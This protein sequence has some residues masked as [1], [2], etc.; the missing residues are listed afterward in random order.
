MVKQA[1]EFQAQSEL[2][3]QKAQGS[4][5]MKIAIRKSAPAT[6]GKLEGW[7]GADWATIDHRGTAA[8]FDSNSRPYDVTAAACVAGDRL[9]V[10][11][12]TTEKDLLRNSGEQA[13]APFKTGGC[14]DVMLGVDP[15]AGDGRNDPVPGDMRLLVTRVKDKTVALLYRAKVPGTKEPVPFSSPW[16]TITFDRVT[17]PAGIELASGPISGG[18]FVEAKVPWSI[19]GITPKAG[20]KLRGDF[21]ILSADSG[22]TSCVARQYWNNKA[23]NLVNDVPGE[24]EL[25]PAMWGEIGVE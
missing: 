25:T 12:R 23:T 9:Y 1:H 17:R 10:V 6:D 21:G 14:L 5:V 22:G 13:T 3:R 11:W 20:A 16:R 18:F 15:K 4:G 7:K 24:A 19:L 8:N 2:A